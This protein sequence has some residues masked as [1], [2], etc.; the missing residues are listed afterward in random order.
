MSPLALTAFSRLNESISLDKHGRYAA[1]LESLPDAMVVVNEGGDIVVINAQA[2]RHFG[3]QREEL[4]GQAVTTI[5]PAGFDGRLLADTARST[6][7]ASGHMSRR[8]EG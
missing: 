6:R 2:E 3:W 4:I 1:L 8:G 7:S 5:I